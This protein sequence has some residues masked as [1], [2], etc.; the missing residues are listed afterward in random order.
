MRTRVPWRGRWAGLVLASV[1]ALGAG[2]VGTTDRNDFNREVQARGGGLTSE[3]PTSAVDAVAE[4]LGVFDFEVRTVTVTPLDGTVV[5]D[6]RDPAA[7]GNLDRY[8][9]RRGSVWQ[10]EPV[11]LTAEDV[12]DEQTFPVSSVALDQTEAMVDAALAEFAAEGYVTSLTVVAAAGEIVISLAL[13][14][15]RAAGTARFTGDGELI[16]VIRT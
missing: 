8:V 16:E 14:S 15:P 11:R 7:P 2:C 10:V 6:V 5:L 1:A 12:L 13:E 3:L 4:A 9:V